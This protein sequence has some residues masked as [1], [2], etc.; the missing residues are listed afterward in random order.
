MRLMR[1][2]R[3][4]LDVASPLII[5]YF[6]MRKKPMI[7]LRDVILTLG[8]I[9]MTVIVRHMTNNHISFLLGFCFIIVLLL[10][11]IHEASFSKMLLIGV[12]IFN[13]Q[14]MLEIPIFILISDLHRYIRVP[15]SQLLVLFLSL[16]LCKRFQL[17]KLFNAMQRNVVPN[18][19]LKQMILLLFSFLVALLLVSPSGPDILL[20]PSFYFP[21]LFVGLILFP[22]T[23]RLYQK[24]MQDMISI[25]E[26]HNALLSTGI[27]IR[28]VSHLD[29]VV[30]KFDEL[31]KRFGIDLSGID[32]YDQSTEDMKRKVTDFI[33]LKQEQRQAKI[34]V[35]TD[36][37]YYKDHQHVDFQQ[38]LH[39]LGTLFDNAIE[40]SVK[41]PIKVRLMVT[42]TRLS[43]S[44]TNDFIKDHLAD[45]SELFEEG[46]STKG[47]GRGLGL[48]HLQQ[49][50]SEQGGRIIYFDQYDE[51]HDCHYLTLE[52]EFK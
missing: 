8:A 17:Y 7:K 6:L 37:G 19:V 41:Q 15:L 30:A 51:Q 25:H 43:L 42:S 38:I 12:L 46:Y 35:I 52:I 31:S 16:I 39:W 33:R 47:D 36:I 22:V 26:L 4:T 23:K 13:L 50:V 14:L 45:F 20:L 24:S 29:E 11:F 18:L 10:K 3:A 5:S 9:G 49:S 44:V 32:F 48:Y 34:E 1:L 28:Q 2:L 21:F 40:A 27:A